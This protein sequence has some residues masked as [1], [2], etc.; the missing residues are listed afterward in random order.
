MK[1]NTAELAHGKF[2]RGSSVLSMIRINKD[3]ELFY[4]YSTEI[5]E[6]D[7]NILRVNPLRYS[8][9]TSKQMA[10]LKR[11]CKKMGCNIVNW[12]TGEVI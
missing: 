4:S 3:K 6:R 11:A 10:Y 12:T 7:G 2:V 8:N 9:T 1:L 5:A